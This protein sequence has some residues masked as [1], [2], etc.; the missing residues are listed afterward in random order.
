[1]I[2]EDSE[3]IIISN[4]RKRETNHVKNFFY[5][6]YFFLECVKDLQDNRDLQDKRFSNKKTN[7]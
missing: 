7:C 6:L 4:V 5:S 1:M 2:E 3:L